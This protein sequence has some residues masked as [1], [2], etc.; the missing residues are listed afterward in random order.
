MKNEFNNDRDIDCQTTLDKFLQCLQEM[1]LE[2]TLD[3]KIDDQY[4][5]LT[6]SEITLLFNPYVVNEEDVRCVMYYS[7]EKHTEIGGPSYIRATWKG[8]QTY[9]PFTFLTPVV[10]WPEND[11]RI[12]FKIGN[13]QD[14]L[15]Q[16]T[17]E[18][19]VN[20]LKKS[21]NSG[22]LTRTITFEDEKI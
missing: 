7:V 5:K 21:L 10:D 1:C 17:M 4:Y 15:N 9:G 6:F 12:I 11:N 3:Q 2:I 22:L 18:E 16:T 19:F 13:T 8:E 14:E 20:W